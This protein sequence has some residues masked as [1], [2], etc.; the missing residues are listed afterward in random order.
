V[1]SG[2]LKDH[3]V[4]LT[5]RH[6]DEW[7]VACVPR[8]TISVV[9]AARYATG[10]VWDGT[11]LRLSPDAPTEYVDLLTGVQLKARRSRL[12]LSECFA[13]VPVSV[14]VSAN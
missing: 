13:T 2:R 14:L 4:A 5:R 1:T 11:K 8:L 12:D 7:V 10:S 9:G 3:A 6:H